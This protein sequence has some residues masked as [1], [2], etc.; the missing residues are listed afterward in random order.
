M[1]HRLQTVLSRIRGLFTG[2]AQDDELAGE[3]REHIR[4]LAADF[5]RRGMSP[6]DAHNAALRQFGGIARLQDELHDRRGLPLVETIIRDLRYS[7]RS[8]SQSPLFA[9]TAILTLALGIGANTAIFTLTDQALLRTLPV[10]DPRQIVQLDWRGPFIGGSMRGGHTFSYPGYKDLRDGNPGVL[11]GLAARYQDSV[12]IADHGPSDRTLAELVSGNYFE[13]LGVTAAIGRTLLPADE[14]AA[15]ASP[16]AVLSYDY[17]SRRF[18]AD[19]SIL[20]RTLDVNGRPVTVVGVA[21]RGFAGFALMSPSD[22]FLPIPMKKVVTP[23]W[24]DLA[25]RNSVWL[26]A[27]GRLKPGVSLQAAAAGLAIPYHRLLE[28]DLKTVHRDANFSARYLRGSINLIPAAKGYDHLQ[29]SFAQPLYLMLAMVGTLLLITC[30]NVANLLFSR[31]ASR[32][33]EIAVRLSLGAT[34]GA[35]VRLIL[36]ESATLAFTGGALGLALSYWVAGLLV[37]VMPYDNIGLAFRIAPDWR[38]LGFTAAVSV[39]AALLFGLMPA[40]EAT[41]PVA[42]NLKGQ[43]TSLRKVL[44]A[45]Q[46]ALSL[47][48][49]IGAGL[50]ARSLYKLMSIDRGIETAH[51][52][53]FHTDPSLHGYSSARAR[54]MALNLQ[55]RIRSIPGVVG[56][57]G[58][59]VAIFANDNWTNTVHVEGYHPRPNEE[60]TF[61]WNAVTPGFFSTLGIPLIAGRDFTER[62]AGDDAKVMI[63]NESLAR[64][65]APGRGIVGLHA[66]FG[67]DGPTAVEIIG[68][69][70][71]M[72]YNDLTDHP[73]PFHYTSLLEGP[74]PEIEMYVRTKGDPLGFA[75]AVRR[76]LSRL[77]PA[78]PMLDVET[79]EMRVDR[80]H[81]LDRLFAWLSGAFGLL[82][83]LLASIGLYGVT[84]FAVARR[85]REIGIRI[86]LGARGENVLRMVMREVLLLTGIG[87]AAGL[88]LAL[89]LGRYLESQLYQ[90]KGID[91]P[92]TVAATAAILIVSALAGY[93]PAR[94]AARIDPL[95]ALRYE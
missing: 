22:I 82:A 91:P 12:D 49:L 43:G 3:V 20:N 71:D 68:V 63:V 48:L 41:R 81:Y 31:G 1:L 74:F 16:Y 2:R 93:L 27:F 76:E 89:L 21:Q 90:M 34:R 52:L 69:V 5:V 84:A 73:R 9:A 88:P 64:H 87:V 77:D 17:W 70:K 28:N 80:T 53:S 46:V 37:R 78:L 79:V 44:V 50:F 60:T 35:L 33:R 38:I 18:G 23:T 55:S 59:F 11:T 86:A 24:D 65:M 14:Q 92:T 56:A 7:L 36:M 67:S 4:L 83:T 8:L 26:M 39:V 72:K 6:A 75:P 15:G 85:T 95:R 30:V 19:P 45:A 66:G 47:L 32:R 54:Q 29:K 40:L 10:K 42:R 94:R 62:D 57:A 13:V 51:L 25:R 61:G 58:A